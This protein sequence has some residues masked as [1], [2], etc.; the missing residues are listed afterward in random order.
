MIRRSTSPVGRWVVN[1]VMFAIAVLVASIP[2][3]ILGSSNIVW[4]E[5]NQYGQVHLPGTAV[6]HLP[7]GS[8][9]VSVAIFLAGR[10]N[11]TPAL[12]FPSDLAL[13]LT[14][15]DGTTGQPTVTR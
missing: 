2:V 7:A 5:D 3:G 15:V 12:P 6:L 4:G 14:P 1:V 11:A 8:V 13:T 10:G 9:R